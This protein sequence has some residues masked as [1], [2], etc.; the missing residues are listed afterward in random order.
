MTER[1]NILATKRFAS[2]DMGDL[3]GKTFEHVYTHNKVFLKFT[4]EKMKTGTGIFK[5]WLDFIKLRHNERRSSI[6]CGETH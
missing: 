1:L 4:L 2:A 3:S 5:L 6:S